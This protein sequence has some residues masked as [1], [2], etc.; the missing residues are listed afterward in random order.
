M[1]TGGIQVKQLYSI[2]FIY[3]DRCELDK[4]YSFVASPLLQIKRK[5][6]KTIKQAK[7]LT[8]TL[9]S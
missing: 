8:C 6:L 9:Y 4:E 2:I 3:Y 1:P 5:I 7:D